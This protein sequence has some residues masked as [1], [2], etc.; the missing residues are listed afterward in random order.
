[1]TGSLIQM[2]LFVFMSDMP[3]RR[4]SPPVRTSKI[5]WKLPALP[6]IRAR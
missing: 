3:S 4:D 5:A 6:G 1:M 2:A